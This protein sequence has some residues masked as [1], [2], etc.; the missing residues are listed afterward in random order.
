MI[1]SSA[2]TLALGLI[3]VLSVLGLPMG[4]A[5]ICASVLYLQ[6]RGQDMGIVAEQFLNGM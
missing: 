4:L 5:M 2:F 3:I 6:M 1:L